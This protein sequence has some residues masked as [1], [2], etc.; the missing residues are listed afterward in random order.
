MRWEEPHHPGPGLQLERHFDTH[1]PT[2]Q[3]SPTM[4]SHLQANDPRQESDPANANSLRWSEFVR[5]LR[6][7]ETRGWLFGAVVGGGILGLLINPSTAWVLPALALLVGLGVVFWIADR[8]AAA[9]FWEVY[10]RVR[11]YELGGRT[12]LPESTPLLRKG[13]TTSRSR[14]PSSPSALRISPSST[15]RRGAVRSPWRSSAMPSA[16]ASGG[17]PW[18]A[19]RSTSALRSSSVPARTKSGPAASS[20]PPSS[21]GWPSRRRASSR[22]SWSTAASSP[23]SP[24]T[25]KPR[26]TSTR[27]RRR[28]GRSRAACSR[29]RRR[30]HKAVGGHGRLAA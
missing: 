12:R 2:L 24:G 15:P 19:R 4:K 23:T 18:R 16:G 28:R 9:A 13:T 21:S 20:R 22:S 6:L 30:L 14:P 26:R 25:R 10:A 5:L 1:S 29:S 27:S 11:G 17:S 7:P 3:H 8:N